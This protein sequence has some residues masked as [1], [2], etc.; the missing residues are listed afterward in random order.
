MSDLSKF[1][2]LSPKEQ[3]IVSVAI[4]IDGHDAA[5]YLLSDRERKGALSKA[6]DDLAQ[7]PPDLRLPLAGTLLRR[8]LER[9]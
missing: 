6:A 5:L 2:E 7:L 4:L 9:L 8:A 3:A 1:R